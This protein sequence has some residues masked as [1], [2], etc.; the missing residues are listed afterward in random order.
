LGKASP[1]TD[2]WLQVRINEDVSLLK[3]ILKLLWLEEQRNPGQVFDHDFITDNTTGYHALIK[4]IDRYALNELI[5]RSGVSSENVLKAA[6]LIAGSKKI[7]ACWAMG[8]TQHKNAVDNIR[9]VVNLLLLKGSIGKPGAGTCPVRGHSNVQGDRTMGIY[10]KPSDDFLN[11]LKQVFGFEPPK[12]H[13]YD[14]VQSIKAMHDGKAKIFFGLGGNFLSATPDTNFT[15]TA[16]RNC[17]L[18]VHVSTKLNR[19]HLV[20]GRIAII[21]PCLGRTEI[22]LQRDEVQFV[23]VENSAG[24][25]H[26]SK[27]NLQPMSAAL[28]SEPKIVATLAKAVLPKSNLDWEKLSGNYDAIRDLIEKTIPGFE[29]YN[30]RVRKPGGFYLPNAAREG[31]FKTATLKANFSINAL[32]NHMLNDDEFLMMTIRS[33][34]QYNTTIYGLNGTKGR[35]FHNR[36]L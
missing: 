20:H 7:I 11:D 3:A 8:L 17:D 14:T 13:G 15:A 19:S 24:V 6:Q 21:L 9:E 23:S 34:D 16:L 27:G 28:W 22:D 10:E 25:V 18:T 29:R 5:A 36:S 31:N 33:H 35:K 2:L 30:D 26:Q 32:S 1:I 12:H 4:D